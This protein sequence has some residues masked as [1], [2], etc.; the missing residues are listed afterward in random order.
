V[1]KVLVLGAGLMGPAIASDLLLFGAASEV[2]I[3]DIDPSRVTVGVERA[4]ATAVAGVKLSAGST[5]DPEREAVAG[6]I[7]S[8]C[9]GQVLDLRD[10]RALIDMMSRAD[11]VAGA[12]PVA[13]VREVTEA[14]I[15]A[16]VGL[17]DLTGSAEGFDIFDYHE[18][19]LQAGVTI[20]PG[21]GVAPGLTNV[22]AGQGAA[23]LDEVE[24]GVLYVGGL[25]AHPLPPLDY[26]VVFS[27]DTVIDEYVA[28]C[29]IVRDGRMIEVPALDGLE[30]LTFPEPVGRCEAFYTYGLG[31]LSRT[32]VGIGFRELGEKTVRYPG[33]RDK[34]L[35]LRECGLLGKEAVLVDGRTVVPRRLTATVL[36]P[37]LARGAE[38]DITVLRAVVRGKKDGREAGWVFEMVDRFDPATRTT[39]MARTTGYTCAIIAGLLL[40]GRIA[41]RGV[42]PLEHVFAATDLYGELRDEMARR[43]MI[44][45]ERKLEGARE[46]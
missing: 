3:A 24:E 28:P 37:L 38:A 34:V 5:P 11:L 40:R 20:L 13:A 42:V 31:T 43:G 36:E 17:C 16:K 45:S 21:C 6:D 2:T 33:H 29:L 32:G 19:A 22:L 23:R 15:E 46:C 30:E 7:A 27:I 25:P 18:A 39:S 26:R 35:F 44:I 4:I 8:R 10:R 14:A 1:S 12:Y 41:A 9:R